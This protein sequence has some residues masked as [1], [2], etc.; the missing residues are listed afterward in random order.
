M[1]ARSPPPIGFGVSWRLVDQLSPSE[2]FQALAA[3]P[4]CLRALLS[5]I[6]YLGRVKMIAGSG[7]LPS[8]GSME[9]LSPEDLLI[10]HKPI[11]EE[12]WFDPP[13]GEKAGPLVPLERFQALE[14]VIRDSPINVDPYL[15][16][17]RIYLQASRWN[18]AKRVLELAVGRFPENEEANYLHEEAKINR[19]LQ[20]LKVAKEEHEAEPTRLTLET[21]NRCNMELNVLREKVCRSRLARN[22]EQLELNIPLATALENLGHVPEAI[23]CLIQAVKQPELR[24]RAGI[25]LGQLYERAKQVPQ[26]LSAY[27]R[28]AFFRVPAPTDEEKILALTSLANLAQ[29]CGM[30]D[31]CCRYTEMLLE[32]QPHNQHLKQ[33]LLELQKANA[34][35]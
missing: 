35:L 20:L 27:R 10:R 13:G 9:P 3:R 33:R 2:G 34:A 14:H 21:L 25:H 5:C 28:A 11:D 6:R 4:A 22:P 19:S 26:A 8:G 31:S 16:L 1:E 32:M 15:E 17:A 30:V 7:Y 12:H 18:D 29:R 23:Q 24:A